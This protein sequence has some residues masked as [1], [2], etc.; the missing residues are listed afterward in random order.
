M[1]NMMCFKNNSGIS[2]AQPAQASSA[3]WWI[4]S[5]PLYGE[6]FSHFQNLSGVQ[7]NGDASLTDASGHVH[8]AVDH[9]TP[10]WPTMQEKTNG[11]GDSPKFLMIPDKDSGKWQK[12]HQRSTTIS[13][14]SPS[15][16]QG[17]FE[18][19]LGQS[20]VCSN[21]PYVDQFY[22]LFATYDTQAMHGQMLLPLNMK[23]EGPIYVNAKQYHGIVRRR[24]ARAKAEMKNKLIKSRKPYLHESRHLHAMRR[25]RG[26]GGRFLNTKKDADVQ[27]AE[28]GNSKH[29][30]YPSASPSSENFQSD[31]GNLNSASCGSSMSGSEVTSMY[32]LGGNNDRFLSIDRTRPSLYH[33]PI[34]TMMGG[35]HG[36]GLP[37]KWGKA[38]D[39]CR[40]LLKV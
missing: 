20:M 36:P 11:G 16:F 40:D 1:Q 31:S 24:K 34:S 4:G 25:P 6:S 38:A 35:D 33:R 9:M 30:A 29:A 17:C 32:S 22:G 2:L 13:L 18:L 27:N 23:A 8:A 7:N 12:N 26:C 14:Q 39:G 15:S 5:Q 3:P 21:Y 37:S 19:G 28:P 10:S